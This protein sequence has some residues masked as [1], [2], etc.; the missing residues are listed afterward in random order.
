M[1]QLTFVNTATG[2]YHKSQ[3]AG[4]WYQVLESKDETKQA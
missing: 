4:A 2:P 3:A 1:V